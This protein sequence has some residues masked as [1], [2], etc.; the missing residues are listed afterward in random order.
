MLRR[1][2]F[3]RHNATRWCSLPDFD[4]AVAEAASA[5]AAAAHP[6]HRVLLVDVRTR[7][8][9]AAAHAPGAVFLEHGFYLEG[10]AGSVIR[11]S[12]RPFAVIG[13]GS[14]A[15]TADAIAALEA[16][17][18]TGCVAALQGGFEAWGRHGRDTASLPSLTAAE[19]VARQS[20]DAQRME[21][22]S[23][24][25]ALEAA[26]SSGPQSAPSSA[27]SRLG[28]S[29]TSRRLLFD[30]RSR[31]EWDAG[32]ARGAVHCPIVVD[33]ASAVPDGSDWHPRIAD[34]EAASLSATLHA[35]LRTPTGGGQRSS[36]VGEKRSA[37]QSFAARRSQRQG[38]P[39][40][41][42]RVSATAE[43]PL[44]R[45]VVV[46]CAGG[47][48][49]LTMCCLMRNAMA[50]SRSTAATDATATASN[51]SFVNLADGYSALQ[52]VAPR[53]QLELPETGNPVGAPS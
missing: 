35:A 21:E 17:G 42:E 47:Y 31:E 53:D 37:M 28:S 22:E 41:A 34:A 2:V 20:R 1:T 45:S 46:Y 49:S 18:F 27:Q 14:D 4:C 9:F 30:V 26:H 52:R 48:R 39:Q 51:V 8:Q 5:S 19:L 12:R 6:S 36:D 29:W 7:A 33:L 3:H 43:P 10:W 38:S 50:A 13:D 16:R 23:E 40:S 24:L 25:R 15:R 44:P 32:R 11:H